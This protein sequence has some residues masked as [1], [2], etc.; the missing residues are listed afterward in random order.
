MQ[1]IDSSVKANLVGMRVGKQRAWAGLF[2]AHVQALCHKSVLA[3]AG[4]GLLRARAGLGL[5][6]FILHFL[7]YCKFEIN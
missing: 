4:P 7:N 3:R 2:Q 6:L 5:Y 1:M